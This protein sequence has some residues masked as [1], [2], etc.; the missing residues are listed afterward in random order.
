MTDPGDLDLAYVAARLGHRTGER[1]PAHPGHPWQAAVSIVLAPGPAGLEVA[2]IQRREH[3]RDRWSGH[4][5]LPGGKREPTDPDLAATA[6]RET[7]EEV[8]LALPAPIGRLADQRGRSTRGL[9]AAFVFGLED[10]PELRPQASEVAA[11]DWI[12]LS[13]LFDP[14]NAVRHRWVGMPFPGIAHRERVIWG[15]THRILT[16]F[17]TSV[18][19]QLPRP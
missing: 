9:V 10:R 4:M 15:L 14:V 3:P 1:S 2:F 13:W 16:D 12:G 6:T 18:G 17:A 19:L 11:A 8:G 5:A 7:A